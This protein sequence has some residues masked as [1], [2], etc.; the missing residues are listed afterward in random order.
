MSKKGFNEFSVR[1]VYNYTQI[2]GAAAVI[3]TSY[4]ITSDEL[5]T[6]LT[7]INDISDKVWYAEEGFT[8][9]LLMKYKDFPITRTA[10]SLKSW[11][12]FTIARMKSKLKTARKTKEA[13]GCV[14]A[15]VIAYAIAMV[16]VMKEKMEYENIEI[17]EALCR[18]EELLG[19]SLEKTKKGK[20]TDY[21]D[22]IADSIDDAY[23]ISI[24]DYLY[25]V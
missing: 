23:N 1:Y 16:Y 21:I 25:E 22:V 15:S 5:K 8:T 9:N 11:Q 13:L 20:I 24:N 3:D 2:I 18:Y 4:D 7:E 6:Y 19:D 14:D 12:K 10:N 17:M